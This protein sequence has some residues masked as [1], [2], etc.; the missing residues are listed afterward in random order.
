M[1]V[2]A[3]SA[4][5]CHVRIGCDLAGGDVGE[6]GLDVEGESTELLDVDRLASTELI[7]EIGDQSSPDDLHL[8]NKMGN[9]SLS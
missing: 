8:R 9:K 6:V 5:R 3:G 4:L 2:F 7:V 1:D